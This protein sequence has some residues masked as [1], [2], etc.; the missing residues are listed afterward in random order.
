MTPRVTNPG[1]PTRALRTRGDSLE[2][3]LMT[4]R[5]M[6]VQ[7]GLRRSLE[8]ARM[9]TVTPSTDKDSLLGKERTFLS[10]LEHS[11]EGMFVLNLA[12]HAVHITAH[13]YTLSHS[14]FGT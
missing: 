11:L 5:D 7:N 8:K 1:A 9:V 4:S 14:S 13:K 2:K 12:L 10:S 3:D 6:H